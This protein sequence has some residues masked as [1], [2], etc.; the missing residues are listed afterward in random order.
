MKKSL[1]IN[2]AV[3]LSAPVFALLFLGEESGVNTLLYT[4]LM[5]GLLFVM[6]PDSWEQAPV[7]LTA[8][9]TV[10]LALLGVIHQSGILRIMHVLSFAGWIGF[11][12]QRELRFWG[13]ALFLAFMHLIEA[14][15]RV[16]QESRS[17]LGDVA[18]L[19]TGIQFSRYAVVPGLIV[20]LFFLIYYFANPQFAS[21]STWLAE[22][23]GLL[24]S[25]GG[26]LAAGNC[27]WIGRFNISCYHPV[28]FR[29]GLVSETCRCR[30]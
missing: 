22:K 4:L 26:F 5:G 11:V 27:L 2:L 21:R 16:W 17:I 30:R 25:N 9:G 20:G 13:N 10:L 23:I 24:Y 14:P 6:H 3:F 12:Q 18:W 19:K 28:S 29:P 7:R 8:I 15:R 1:A